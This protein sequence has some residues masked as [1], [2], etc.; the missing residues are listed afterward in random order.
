MDSYLQISVFTG[1]YHQRQTHALPNFTITLLV[2]NI[3]FE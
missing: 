2:K 3:P 1:F